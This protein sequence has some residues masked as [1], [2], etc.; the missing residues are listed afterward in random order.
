MSYRLTIIF[1]ILLLLVSS[2]GAAAAPEFSVD[3]RESSIMDPNDYGITVQEALAENFN[4][5]V[6]IKELTIINY[7]TA[8]E[9][10]LKRINVQYETGDGNWRTARL[11]E[12]MGITSG[13][14]FSLQ[15]DGV[16][17]D[18]GDR[19]QFRFKVD[20]E[21]PDRIPVSKYGSLVSVEL[22]VMFHYVY[23]NEEGDAIDSV[24]S[25]WYR[26]PHPDVI[27]RGGFE[28]SE[29]VDLDD[30]YLHPGTTG[31]IGEYTFVDRDLNDAG[32]QVN[33]MEVFNSLKVNNPMV[34]GQD[35]T[36]LSL[37]VTVKGGGTE[38]KKT[39][40][41]SIDGPTSKVVFDLSP[42]AWWD[43][44][45]PDE[46]V[47]HVVVKGKIALDE[48]L[49]GGLRLRTGMSL[50]AR[51][52]NGT[53]GFPF[54]RTERVP[55]NSIQTIEMHGLEKMEETTV[56]RSKVVNFGETYRQR[57]LLKDKDTDSSDFYLT[58][59]ALENE[60]SL[61]N[62]DFDDISVFRVTE[63]GD[64]AEIGSGLKFGGSWQNLG[65]QSESYVPDQGETAIEIHYSVSPDAEDGGTF[66]PIV[67]FR[68]TEGS[69]K[70]VPGPKLKSDI[71]LTVHPKGAESVSSCRQLAGLPALRGDSRV[72]VQRIDVMDKDEN[73]FDLF[74]N[75]IVVKNMG[76]ATGADFTKMEIFDS[77][78]TLLVEKTDL[79]GLSTAGV[80]FSNLD[81]KT[82]V[83]DD[84]YGNWRSFYIYLTPSAVLRTGRDKTVDLETKL[85]QSEG[86]EDYLDAV[87]GP[88]F[89]VKARSGFSG[90]FAPS[91][92]RT[93]TRAVSPQP[94]GEGFPLS[95]GLGLGASY[96]DDLSVDAR[97]FGQ[98]YFNLDEVGGPQ[99]SG[100]AFNRIGV[101]IDSV[102][103]QWY[104]SPYST[105]AF[106]WEAEDNISQYAGVGAGV[107]FLSS[108]AGSSTA[109]SVHGTYG[110]NIADLFERDLPVF[111]QGRV[112]YLFNPVGK[113][114]FE[115]DVGV[116]YG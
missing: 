38:R 34:L 112:K 37:E 91:P 104:F 100:E 99:R 46:G 5:P 81:G 23:L 97:L 51:E 24:S 61:K 6:R 76:T 79:A 98:Y 55:A 71:D 68:G 93:E 57:L 29:S 33:K 15:G 80:T 70:Q 9:N 41:R 8:S 31:V 72:L 14:T 113:A 58:E 12:L 108:T 54:V 60:G 32:V 65:P 17:L 82:V 4:R 13:V 102:N 22:G 56:W 106:E 88:A 7:G 28:H 92:P 101:E 20:V 109:I 96:S 74:I 53:S 10:E 89:N 48:N 86:R 103:D 39:M 95:V 64:L 116:L 90:V 111:T 3:S 26:D 42:D 94:V 62:A 11:N 105:L 69:A 115:V 40:T 52:K 78:G 83:R 110:V 50:N 43:G 47:V 45:V 66:S 16:R 107:A 114:V 2:F 36:E 73:R 63:D 30:E 67:Q 35:I 84:Q 87:R 85:Y 25:T 1:S 77:D 75:P 49:R 59:V 18:K 19:S 27:K 44:Q 21:P